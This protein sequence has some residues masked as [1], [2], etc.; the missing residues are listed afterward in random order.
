MTDLHHIGHVRVH[1]TSI[2]TS[3]MESQRMMIIDWVDDALLPLL[4]IALGT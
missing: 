4:S 1:N 2:G 3:D